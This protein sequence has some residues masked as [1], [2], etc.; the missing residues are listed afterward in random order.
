LDL[1][2]AVFPRPKGDVNALVRLAG[3][4]M[5]EVDALIIDRMQSDVPI[6]PRLAEHLVSAGGKRLRPL[7]TVAAARATGAQ[8]DILSP[9]KLAAA[10]EFMDTST[11]L[12]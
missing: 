9:K 12:H 8:G 1:A 4:D 6:I 2:P 11:L 10:V 3:T 5:A 7:L